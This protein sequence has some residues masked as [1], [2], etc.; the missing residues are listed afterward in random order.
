MSA[1]YGFK[2]IAAVGIFLHHLAFPYSMG[3]LFTTFFFVFAGFITAYS[4]KKKQ[5]ICNKKTLKEFYISKL[6]K[7]YPIYIATLLISIP[8]V[9]P[10]EQMTIQLKDFFVHGLML[11]VLFPYGKKT[12]MFNG[13]SW[14]LADL[15]IFY[16][17]IPFIYHT[18]QKMK[19]ETSTMKI[20]TCLAGMFFVDF[21]IAYL[22]PGGLTA[23]SFKWWFLYISPFTRIIHYLMGFF[24]G[25]LFVLHQEKWKK[26]VARIPSLV[27][28]LLEMG[29]LS[30]L[31]V[32]IYLEKRILNF[33]INE[34][35]YIVTSFII[36]V[37]FA[38]EKGYLSKLLSSKVFVYLGKMSFIIY[39]LHQVII[40]YV[41]LYLGVRP[42]YNVNISRFNN[43]MTA[44]ILFII[45]LALCDVSSRYIVIPI[46]NWLQKKVGEKLCKN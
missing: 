38:L 43:M 21:I 2:F 40:N 3:R 32:A 12:F 34:I 46:T 10:V 9:G 29:A 26:L 14:F 30:L 44:F 22:F 39:M 33:E 5:F 20:G 6:I 16:F 19:I 8:I 24:F 23:Y 45:V 28:T 1:L 15:M 25:L 7:N 42:W 27:Y 35:V 37:I 18:I 17:I 11:Q 41:S 31:L 4:F 13:L 36:I